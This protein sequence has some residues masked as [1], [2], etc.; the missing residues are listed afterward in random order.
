MHICFL[1]TQAF[2][3]SVLGMNAARRVKENNPTF[4][5]SFAVLSK[6]NLTTNDSPAGLNEVL[7][8]AINQPW[9]DAVGVAEVNNEGSITN[10]NFNTDSIPKIEKLILQNRWYSDL[11]I[12]R[13]NNVDVKEFLTEEQYLDGNIE[14][15]VKSEKIKDNKVRIATNGPLDWNRK[16][17]SENVRLDTLYGIKEILESK[18]IEFELNLF[19]VDV[20]ITTLYQSLQLL[21]RHDLFIGPAGSLT[22][23]STALGL[24]TISIPSVFPASYDLPEFYSTKGYHKTINHREENHCGDFKCVSEKT[25]NGDNHTQG[26]PPTRWGFWL[27]NCPYTES[28]WACTKTVVAKDILDEFERWLNVRSK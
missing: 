4:T 8:V 16:L 18:N 9:I 12:S 11:G 7:E 6:F 17:Q 28:K 21:N 24:D 26:N 27:R 3:D 14:L 15:S 25:H 10:F 13:S 1:N 22:H 19:G 2:G 5:I 23:C 20:N